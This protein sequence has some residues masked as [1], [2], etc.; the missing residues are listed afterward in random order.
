MLK[1]EVESFTQLQR[2]ETD[3]GRHEV[4]HRSGVW[5]SDTDHPRQS[6]TA[7]HD[8]T[9]VV[10]EAGMVTVSYG[11]PAGESHHHVHGP[12]RGYWS[13]HRRA[14]ASLENASMGPGDIALV[15]DTTGKGH[16]TRV[17]GTEELVTLWLPLTDH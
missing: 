9:A 14:N 8:S 16:I 12:R 2:S 6:R 15:E 17:T 13:T 3:C 1:R 7:R 4:P 11:E 5:P 10:I